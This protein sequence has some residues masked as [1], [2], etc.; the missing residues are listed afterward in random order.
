[1]S[2]FSKNKY[3]F[4]VIGLL[5][6]LSFPIDSYTHG[7]DLTDNDT[8]L[9]CHLC[10]IDFK[11]SATL[12]IPQFIYFLV[13]YSVIHPELGVSYTTPRQLTIRAPPK[14]S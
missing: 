3:L 11:E 13:E 2:K 14:F 9:D 8:L 6:I 5:F 10:K 1:V 7:A 12:S 4:S